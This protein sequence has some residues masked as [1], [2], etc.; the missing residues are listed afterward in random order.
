M[1]LD[2]RFNW[3]QAGTC[4][5]SVKYS[6]GNADHCLHTDGNTLRQ[7]SVRYWVS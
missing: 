6:V 4:L 7:N 2:S 5:K 3:Y 1:I